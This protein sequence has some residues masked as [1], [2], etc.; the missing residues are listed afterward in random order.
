MTSVADWVPEVV[1][2]VVVN[3]LHINNVGM[4]FGFVADDA[5]LWVSLKIHRKSDAGAGDVRFFIQT[6]AGH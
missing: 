5:C 4:A 1:D 2:L 6:F 3:I